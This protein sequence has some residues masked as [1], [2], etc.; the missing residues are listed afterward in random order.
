[1]YSPGHGWV[2]SILYAIPSPFREDGI[3]S[4][5]GRS[6]MPSGNIVLEPQ[7]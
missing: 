2:R 5:L 3:P 1:M 7:N 6:G 4:A